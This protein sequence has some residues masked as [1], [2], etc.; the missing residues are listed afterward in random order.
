MITI[1]I[2][3]LTGE[4]ES[5]EFSQEIVTVSLIKIRLYTR[6]YITR[7]FK[8]NE[9]NEEDEKD[10][11]K[12]KKEEKEL[13]DNAFVKDGDILCLFKEREEFLPHENKSYE[14][15]LKY[16]LHD[17]EKFRQIIINNEAIIA[18]GSVLSIFGRFPMKD[19]DI[20]VNYSNAQK[21]LKELY[22]FGFSPQSFH[23]AP[24][25]DDSFFRKNNIM[26]RFYTSYDKSQFGIIGPNRILDADIMVIPDH[27]PLE[28]VVT[29]FDLTF[30]QVWWDGN[31]IQSFD[32]EDIRTKKGSL[33]KDYVSSYLNMNTFIINRI[34]KYRNR[35]FDIKIDISDVS[36]NI[37]RNIKKTADPERWSVSKIIDYVK[38]D[39]RGY[40]YYFFFD[41]FPKEINL[42]GLYEK[43][44]KD[45]ID[46]FVIRCFYEIYDNIPDNYRAYFK[47]TF[48][49]VIG[50]ISSSRSLLH[51]QDHVWRIIRA[52]FNH[53]KDEYRSLY[54]E[55]KILRNEYKQSVQI[56]QNQRPDN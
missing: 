22:I 47:S 1:Y 26:A 19:L 11:K 39:F 21:L 42:M 40:E 10:E 51:M 18:G 34:I 14:G 8:Y 27:I 23:K 50:S 17:F 35:G 28:N 33:N 3:K 12:D 9:D 53:K 2:K 38:D 55:L 25:Y 36:E 48:P 16:N 44:D 20:Y 5:L 54:N 6:G 32:M 45:V 41:V 7:L 15:R 56:K 4:I 49:T 30:C 13:S 46:A 31:K 24:A 52:W 43:M 37:V 29:N